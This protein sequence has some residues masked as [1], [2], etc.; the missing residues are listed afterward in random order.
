MCVCSLVHQKL[1]FQELTQSESSSNGCDH[2]LP[3]GP[4]SSVGQFLQSVEELGRL[5]RQLEEIREER[6]HLHE[7]CKET[8]ASLNRCSN[9]AVVTSGRKDSSKQ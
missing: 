3:I 7:T 1:L 6:I 8:V 4:L 5:K 2:G 9:G